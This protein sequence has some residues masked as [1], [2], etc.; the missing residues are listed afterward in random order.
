MDFSTNGIVTVIPAYRVQ[1]TITTVLKD[2]PAYIKHIIVVDDASPDSS[3]KLVTAAA[4]Q[5]PRIIL[6]RHERN[7]GVGGAMISGFHKA[8]ELGAK[9]VVKLDG[10]G[11]MDS[12]HIPALVTPLIL[13]KADFTKGNRFRDFVSLR[14]MPMVRR[15]GNLGLSFLT[16]AATGYWNIFDPT[17]G[18][19]AIRTEVLKQLPLEAIDKRYFFE[20]SL[21]ANLYLVNAFVMDVPMPARYGN[22][23]SHLSIRRSLLEFPLKLFSTLIRR[24]L[25]KY[26]IYDFSIISL[27]IVTSIPLLL[28]GFIFGAIKW[29][30]YASRNIPA[31]TGTVMLPTLCV[32]LG[33]QIMLSAIE[34][35]MKSTPSQP[36]CDPL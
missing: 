15:V 6:I 4:Q 29:I 17:N 36:I 16:K 27:Y 7:Q 31:P 14:N 19:F 8:L 12:A 1:D 35:D 23:T 22:E 26:Y 25:L 11:Q 13:G 5:D 34:I 30:D 9:I 3:V 33:I 21:L 28:F 2:L 18:F 10:D 20:T 24:I 32:I